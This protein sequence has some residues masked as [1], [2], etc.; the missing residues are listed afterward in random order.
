M[1]FCKKFTNPLMTKP[2]KD[3]KNPMNSIDELIIFIP[4]YLTLKN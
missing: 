3:L 2:H 1:F 4:L